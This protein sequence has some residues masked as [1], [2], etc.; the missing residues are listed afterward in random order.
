MAAHRKNIYKKAERLHWSL[1]LLSF[2][3]QVVGLL[4]ILGGVHLMYKNSIY[5]GILALVG[6]IAIVLL[7]SFI[8]IMRAV[9]EVT[10]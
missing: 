5:K 6:G 7:N 4:C 9:Y 3:V 2:L 8:R 1:E 10:H